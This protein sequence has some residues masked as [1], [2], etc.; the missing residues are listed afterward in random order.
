VHQQL[1]LLLGQLD[2]RA[3]QGDKSRPPVDR[4][5]PRDDPGRRRDTRAP[6]HRPH[7]L[8]ELVVVE[9]ARHVVVASAP[10]CA[11]ALVGLRLRRA[12]NDHRRLPAPALELGVV[13]GEHEIGRRTG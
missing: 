10:K 7:P 2:A 1:V 5:R 13:A 12:E 9:R 4:Q 8:D 11:H 3:V 6:Q